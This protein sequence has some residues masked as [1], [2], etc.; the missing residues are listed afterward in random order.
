MGVRRV[1]LEGKCTV[2]APQ[3]P[4]VRPVLGRHDAWSMWLG[5]LSITVTLTL[6]PTGLGVFICL[7]LSSASAFMVV[8][9]HHEP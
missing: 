7:H 9:L 2:H 4:M 8:P 6:I 5:L 3:L 1:R